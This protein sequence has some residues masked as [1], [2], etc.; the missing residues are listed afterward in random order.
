[1]ASPEP[2]GRLYL[3]GLGIGDVS[4][5]SVRAKEIIQR[6]KNVFLESYTSVLKPVHEMIPS[7]EAFFEREVIAAD[8]EMVESQSDLIIEPAHT[9]EVSLLVVGDPFCATTHSDLYLRARKA[10]VAVTVLHNASI[11]NAIGASGLEVYRFGHTVSV[12]FWTDS[13]RPQSFYT[14]IVENRLS[15]SPNGAPRARLHTLCLLD[16]KVKEQTIEN[17]MR[18]NA[19]Y[20][21]PRF[22]TASQAA[23]EIL[24][25]ALSPD[26][27]PQGP[28][29][30]RLCAD[31]IVV[32][33]A[34]VGGASQKFFTTTLGR[35]AA[36]VDMGAPLHSLVVPGDIE[37]I[38]AEMLLLWADPED[39]EL[40]A[41]LQAIAA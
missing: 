28:E 24:E 40:V 36:G 27:E 12:V 26:A 31:S 15:V 35:L 37:P 11:I 23:E 21:P 1:M 4:D 13:W 18:G 17:M 7:L 14:K 41:R 16:I 33:A 2:S 30:D 22:M 34:R 38:E 29:G 8:R 5:V 39:A 32:A 9:A 10:G 20:E 3:I 19:V 25:C 6:C